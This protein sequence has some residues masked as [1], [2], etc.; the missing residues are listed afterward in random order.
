[1]K[2]LS[3]KEA[4]AVAVA[5]VILLALV[6]FENPIGSG[7]NFTNKAQTA[8]PVVQDSGSEAIVVDDVL[9]GT[10]VEA[11]AGKTVSVNYTGKFTDGQ[12]FDTNLG[13]APFGFVLGSGQVIPGFD[14]G[15][16][17]MKVGGKRVITVPP[18]EAYGSQ[19]VGP[20][21]ANSTLVFEVEMLDVK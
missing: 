15:L 12:V 10:G 4:I 16:A 8:A 21:P 3:T 11:V 1:M 14:K 18:S 17:G 5:I 7:I 13:K 20:I 2:S 6:L 19:Q 9:I